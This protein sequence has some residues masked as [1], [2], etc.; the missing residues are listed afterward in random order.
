MSVTIG[1]MGDADFRTVNISVLVDI[2]T[3]SI[4]TGQP[5]G[6]RIASFVRQVHNP[7]CFRVGKIAVK[8]S[9]MDTG[10]TLE[11]RMVGLLLKSNYCINQ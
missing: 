3:V 9:F 10:P 4:D 1:Q 11:D 7:Y 2:H 8:S 6:D 5:K